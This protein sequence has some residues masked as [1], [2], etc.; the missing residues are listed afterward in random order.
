MCIKPVVALLLCTCTIQTFTWKPF[1]FKAWIILLKITFL[2]YQLFSL[3]LYPLSDFNETLI[4]TFYITSC[5]LEQF[6][7]SPGKQN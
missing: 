5:T 7:S 1:Y 4:S 3:T 2:L 6:L